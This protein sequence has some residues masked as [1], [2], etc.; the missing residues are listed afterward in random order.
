MK[1]LYQ[2]LNKLR[3]QDLIIQKMRYRR[4]TRLVGSLKTMAYA[5]SALMA[6]HLFQTFADGLELTSFD[7]IAMVL[8]MWLFAIILMLEV[9]MAR[10]L[11]GHELIQDLLV[12][13]SQ[14]LNLTVSK[15]SAPMTRGKQ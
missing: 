4:S 5:A 8:V 9:E 13:R 6:G 12:L 3:T 15:G 1:L 2:K 7:V 11:A 10:D 14:R